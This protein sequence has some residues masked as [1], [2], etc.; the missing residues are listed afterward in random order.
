[1]TGWSKRNLKQPMRWICLGLLLLLFLPGSLQAQVRLQ[2]STRSGTVPVGDLSRSRS[3]SQNKGTNT[4][5]PFSTDSTQADTSANKGLVYHKEIPDSVLRQKVFL[6]RHRKAR[7][8]IDEVWNPTL[9][10]TGVQFSDPIDALNGNYYLGKGS[11]GHPHVSLFPTLADGLDIRIR[12]DLYPAYSFRLDNI[13]FFQTLT[14]FSSLSYG[15][16]LAN[17]HSLRIT[18]T[19][20]IMPGWN[21][22]FDYRL[23]NP[24]GVYTS[25]GALNNYLNATT[26]Y[27]SPDS[28]LQASAALIWQS[29]NID[30]NGGLANDS[31]FILRR[32]SNRAGIPVRLSN[33]GSLQR[34]LAAMGSLLYSLERQSNAYRH[35][36]SIVL[37]QVNDSTT[38]LDTLDL[39]DT[40]P[41]RR[42]HILNPGVVGI[43]LNY[44]RQKRLFVDSTHWREQQATLYWTNDAY[45]N[46]RWRNPLKVTL[47]LQ[48][49]YLRAVILGDTLRS[50]SWINPFLRVEATLWRATLALDA[51]Q[52][53]NPWASDG[54]DR[55]F[56]VSIDLPF[57]SAGLTRLKLD[58]QLQ[59]RPADLITVYYHTA[60]TGAASLPSSTVERYSLHFKHQDIIDFSASASHIRRHLW[61]DTL[62]AVHQG[63]QPF[64]LLQAS[65]LLRLHAGPLHLDLQQLLQ[66]STDA[67]QLPLP[68][69]ATKNS[70]YADFPLFGRTLRAQ[71][72]VDLR[73]HTPYHAPL[74]DPASGLFLQQDQLTVGGYLWADAF[75]NLQVKR[76]SIYLKA[77]HLNA[78]WE[79]PATY[80]L[81]PHYPGQAFGLQWGLL[82]TFFD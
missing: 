82:W 80:L 29:F 63:Q 73:Y 19:Q 15:G 7:M 77:G 42:P 34:D 51:E 58:A 64:W 45:P 46:H 30:E 65:L 61:I 44:D 71:L 16:S 4:T 68:L 81:L 56:A 9:D 76:A 8:W 67:L 41:L 25:S 53:S 60:S 32:Q 50:Y 1:M 12:P 28:R 48:P 5:N 23:F 2:P 72:G 36:D 70:I 18:H 37:V 20:N 75:I 39:L 10:P 11:L 21:A 6:F 47:G 31:I 57:D 49:R 40:I 35:R 33:S 55:R 24:E 69:W 52:Q 79:T 22:S 74:Y 3:S 14:P 62:L 59:D 66:H 38:R 17:D 78:L 54:N 26:N 13:N 43:E 27:F